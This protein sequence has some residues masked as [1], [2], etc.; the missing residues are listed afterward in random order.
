MKLNN[1]SSIQYLRCIATSVSSYAK[2]MVPLMAVEV[3]CRSLDS[4]VQPL[5]EELEEAMR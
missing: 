5:V 1:H 3:G 4:S 2:G